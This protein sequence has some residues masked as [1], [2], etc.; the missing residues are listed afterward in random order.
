MSDTGN[1]RQWISEVFV[2]QDRGVRSCQLDRV[3]IHRNARQAGDVLLI[4]CDGHTPNNQVAD[5]M[6]LIQTAIRWLATELTGLARLD[7]ESVA[8]AFFRV[9]RRLCA[10]ADRVAGTTASV[11]YLSRTMAVTA[12][13][14]NSPIFSFD[15]PRIHVWSDD[16]TVDNE[17]ERAR[18][19]KAWF[20]QMAER[21]FIPPPSYGTQRRLDLTRTFGDRFHKPAL[22]AVPFI[23]VEDGQLPGKVL[24]LTTDGLIETLEG[25]AIL[26]R[27]AFAPLSGPGSFQDRAHAFARYVIGLGV[28]DNTSFLL[29]DLDKFYGR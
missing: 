29:F 10:A 12:N 3:L 2:F 24:M 25:K 18:M 8:E 21:H 22:A 27:T 6:W 17:K 14:G 23:H 19:L 11:V 7:R 4:V 28:E 9:D 1:R 26:H 5:G 13:V 20:V 15:G 16:H